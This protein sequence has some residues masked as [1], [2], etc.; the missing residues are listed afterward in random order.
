MKNARAS[1]R[2]AKSLLQLSIEKKILKEVKL[3][4]DMLIKV[5][6]ESRE[7]SNLYTS[8]IIPIK[9]KVKITNKVF[10]NK[11]NENTLN[12]LL[13]VIYRKRD[14]L[15]Q[16]IFSKFNE[17]Y[18]VHNNIEES[19]ITTTYD[20]DDNILND[21]KMFA[22]KVS[23]KKISLSHSINNKIIGGFNLKIGDK[24]IDCT[25]S[26]KINELRKKLINN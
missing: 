8:P 24:M 5:F 11:I 9:H 17:L 23:K 20:L 18:N 15:L 25:V 4:I 16:S 14:N 7:I 21:I 1:E 19:Y 3:D 26:S 6:T 13:N 2:Y 22:E 12:L 10:L